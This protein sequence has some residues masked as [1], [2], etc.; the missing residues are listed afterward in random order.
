M[1]LNGSLSRNV[2]DLHGMKIGNVS[3]F[4]IDLFIS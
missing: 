3:Y 2:S 1:Q 4:D